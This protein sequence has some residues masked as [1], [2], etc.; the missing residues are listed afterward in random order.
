MSEADPEHRN[1]AGER[2]NHVHGYTGVIRR[3]WSGGNTQVRRLQPAGRFGC[4][5]IVAIDLHLRSQHQ[6][7][8]DQVVGEGIIVVDQQQMRL[9][10]PFPTS[11]SPRTM[12]QLL[13]RTSSYSVSGT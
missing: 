9:H 13:A 2:A 3:A 7:R 10:R 4:H 6:E 12:E 5:G 11:S 8:L 1:D